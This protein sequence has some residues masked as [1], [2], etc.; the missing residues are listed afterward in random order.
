MKSDGNLTSILAL[1]A[2]MPNTPHAPL[3]LAI[4]N[5]TEEEAAPFF[6]PIQD[7]GPLEAQIRNIKY[8]DATQFHKM[9][10]L[11]PGVD[12]YYMSMAL[13]DHPFDS[14]ILMSSAQ[15]YL[16]IMQ[17]YGE[18]VY[19]SMWWI[20]LRDFTKVASVPVSATAFANRFNCANIGADF[21]YSGASLDE[22]MKKETQNLMGNTREMAA[23]KRASAKVPLSVEVER[24]DVHNAYANF[25][26]GLEKIES[27][28]GENLPRLRELKKKWDPDML[29]NKCTF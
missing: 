6:K 12:R 18:P 10:P 11:P 21:M 9:M 28:F 19:R 20:D 1:S 29:F 23:K 16:D 17:K 24:R 5:G 15:Q 26:S 27:V 25:T 14:E 13:V 3:W 7:L 22:T 4:Y 8:T 2:M